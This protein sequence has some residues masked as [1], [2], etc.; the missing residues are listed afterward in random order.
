MRCI[1]VAKDFSKTPFGRYKDDSDY[2]AELFR[3]SLLIPL[4]TDKEE[5][6][7]LIDF[8]GIAMGLGS[9]FLEEAFVGMVRKGVDSK[10]IKSRLK[11]V[12]NLPIYEQQILKFIDLA[13]KVYRS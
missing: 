4:F 5:D 2:S 13:A 12:S 8:K 1:N 7:I 10:I 9:S 6:E 11:I 3:D